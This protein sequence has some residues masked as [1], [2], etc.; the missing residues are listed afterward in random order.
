M[1]L[2]HELLMVGILPITDRLRALNIGHLNRCLY[3][4][5]LAIAV[6]AERLNVCVC[7]CVCVC[8]Q[9]SGDL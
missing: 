8:V 3:L 5:S 1:H 9:T 6:A 4:S 7:V 2:R